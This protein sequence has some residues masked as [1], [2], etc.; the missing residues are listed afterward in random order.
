MAPVNGAPVSANC[1]P[2][3]IRIPHISASSRQSTPNS[4]PR[5]AMPLSACHRACLL[6]RSPCNPTP[7]EGSTPLGRHWGTWTCCEHAQDVSRV[8]TGC[9]GTLPQPW[10]SV[11]RNNS[12]LPPSC[13][14]APSR[15][16]SHS[17]SCTHMSLSQS[18][19]RLTPLHAAVSSSE[20]I[21]PR[22][23]IANCFLHYS[24]SM[25]ITSRL[26]REMHVRRACSSTGI[27]PNLQEPAP[28]HPSVIPLQPGLGCRPPPNLMVSQ[29][30]DHGCLPHPAVLLLLPD[31]P[32]ATC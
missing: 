10:S 24:G 25:G 6:P 7:A 14:A 28:T 16:C 21:A 22:A 5:P 9:L 17:S 20:F 3:S 29:R 18:L 23:H 30:H 2:S 4:L 27:L 1:T 26:L 8:G 15:Q 19:S 13:Q 32:A 11:K 12:A 31:L